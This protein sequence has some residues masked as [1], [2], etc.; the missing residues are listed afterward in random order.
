MIRVF[1]WD[2]VLLLLSGLQW[3]LILTFSSLVIGGAL[4]LVVALMRVGVSAP[5]R[6]LASGIIYC[7]QG[8][9]VLMLLFLSYYGLALAGYNVPPLLAAIVALSIFAT[10]YLGD[11]WRGCIQAVPKAQ[12]EVSESLALSRYQ[13]YRY[14][15][16]PQAVRL[17]IPQTVGFLV[18]LV[19]NSAVGSLIGFLELTRVGQLVS[20]ATFDP[21]RSFLLVAL[22]YFI[23]NYPLSLLSG[24]LERRLNV[25]R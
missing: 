7:V 5:L 15:I 24:R 2:D 13:Q 17:A 25:G 21:L 12:W 3:T 23:I 14:V 4:G 16:L 11:I 18:Q 6:A 20:N 1:G 8:V 10:A 22:F 19:K 9:P